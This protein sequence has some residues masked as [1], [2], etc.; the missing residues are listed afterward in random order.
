MRALIRVFSAILV[1]LG[2]WA[3]GVEA[4]DKI[5]VVTTTTDLKA[6]TEAVGGEVVALAA[7]NREIRLRAHRA[8][9]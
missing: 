4:A 6:L 1:A 7:G 8:D 5:R 3:G 9:D 2:L